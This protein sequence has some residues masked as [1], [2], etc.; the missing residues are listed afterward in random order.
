MPGLLGRWRRSEHRFCQEN[1]SGYLDL[2]LPE[3]AR[4]RVERH[5]QECA[6]CRWDLE[7][8]QQTVALLR[9]MPRPRPPRSFAIPETAPAPSLP[10]WMR[11]G[12]YTVMR[13]ATVAVAAVFV[14]AVVGNVAIWQGWA[15]RAAAPASE[16]TFFA[17]SAAATAPA[18]MGRLAA[19]A[20]PP[21]GALPNDT[22]AAPMLGAGAPTPTPPAAALAAP[23]EP[24]LTA[25]EA[26]HKAVAPPG[27]G[28]GEA[29]AV[30]A[31]GPTEPAGAEARGRALEPAATPEA[32]ARPAPQITE[33]RGERP[34]PAAPGEAA[35]DTREAGTPT[36]GIAQ[37]MGLA[38]G[39]RLWPALLYASAVVL[40]LLAAA[41]LWL[42]RARARWP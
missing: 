37:R 5:L 19:T 35:A 13:A 20:V 18:S 4:Q 7:T 2:Q 27:M 9:A 28:G 1:L 22:P 24:T 14:V 32:A 16:P 29:D 34:T 11:P 10:F 25:E 17:Q 33:A 36:A 31:K 41:V 30:P 38:Q 21:A 15:G 26:A 12:T 3:P 42:R 23:A 39:S 40:A 6:R 8:L